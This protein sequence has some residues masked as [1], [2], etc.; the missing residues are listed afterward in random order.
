MSVA[1][2]CVIFAAFTATASGSQATSD[3]EDVVSRLQKRYSEITTLSASFIQE[4]FSAALG[5]TQTSTG[6][7]WF[8]KPGKMRWLYEEPAGDE[9]TSDGTTFWLYQ[10]DLNQVVVRPAEEVTSSI[11]TDFLTGVGVLKSEFKITLD[12]KD[13][14][15]FRLGLMPKK[16]IPNIRKLMIEVTMDDFFIKRTI[17]EDYF[18]NTTTVTFTDISVNEPV[19]DGS[20]R[21]KVPAG[22]AVVKQ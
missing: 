10:A 11:A 2:L 21:F 15:V 13:D 3:V 19:E 1:V 18:G 9:L 12:G 4:A 20:F 8:K 5:S 16:E 17:S 6:K 14:D 7:V 22:A